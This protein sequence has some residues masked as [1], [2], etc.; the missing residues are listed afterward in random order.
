MKKKVFG[1]ALLL[2]M[3]MSLVA[4]GEKKKEE[5]QTNNTITPIN[6]EEKMKSDIE[7]YKKYVQLGNYKNIEVT[8]DD[9][10]LNVTDEDVTTF[11]DNLRGNFAETKELKEGTTKKDDTIKLDYSGTLNGVAFSGGT[12]T[13]VQYT[14]GSG[15]FISD[16]DA[17]LEGLEVG[18]EYQVPCRFPDNYLS[19][20]LAGKDVIFTVKV[21][22][23][24]ERVLPELNEEFVGKVVT[25][26]GFDTDAKTPDEF[27]KFAKEY[28]AESAKSSY[29]SARY[30]E[31][32]N[33]IDSATT[34]SGYPE[35]E[36][37]ST[38]D[39]IKNNLRKE[40]EYYGKASGINTFEDYLKQ[41]Y[42]MSGEEQLNTEAEEYAKSYLKEKMILTLIAGE[43]N[44]TV[45]ED[46]LK[47]FGEE[48]ALENEYESYEQLLNELGS[49]IQL[50]VGYSVMADKV[51]DLLLE[52]SVSK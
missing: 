12:A 25:A 3:A 21:N 7:T 45:G 26:G 6:Y 17:G 15:K 34:V 31:I 50:E 40:F 47:K 42:Q 22:A 20:D 24:I 48:I 51:V 28:L 10:V 8:A 30:Q 2:T 13:D 33:T 18:K 5:N 38:A 43:E 4:C 37:K 16:L 11:I 23:I 36:L 29:D 49:D 14:V 19:A 9:S 1:T 35:E 46:E 52:N 41:V 39:T 44:I 27:K 32:W